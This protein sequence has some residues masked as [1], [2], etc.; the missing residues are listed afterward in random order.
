MVEAGERRLNVRRA[1][2]DTPP[3]SLGI[4]PIEGSLPPAAALPT[5]AATSPPAPDLPRAVDRVELSPSAEVR[6]RAGT[7]SA[8]GRVF[9]LAQQNREQ[10]RELHFSRDE[11][12]GNIVIEVRSLA[13]E[14]IRTI[15]KSEALEILAGKAPW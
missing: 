5:P 14:L 6:S 7:P 1:S 3:V 10:N 12:T 4:P 13:G 8:F 9:E 15:P 2:A 11:D